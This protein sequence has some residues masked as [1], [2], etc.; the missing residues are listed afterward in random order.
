MATGV[1]KKSQKMLQS[2]T[3]LLVDSRQ[4]LSLLSKLLCLLGNRLALYLQDGHL[5]LLV[6][7][8]VELLR[9]GHDCLFG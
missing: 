8:R 3:A 5:R 7:A 2:E 6:D 1:S 4:E 9:F